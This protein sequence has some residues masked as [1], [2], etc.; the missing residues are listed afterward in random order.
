MEITYLSQKS[1][2][3]NLLKIW[4]HEIH[5]FDDIVINGQGLL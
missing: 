2:L 3:I 5:P 1:M 4:L